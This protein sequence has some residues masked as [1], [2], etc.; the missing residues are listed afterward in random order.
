[1]LTPYIDYSFNIIHNRYNFFVA[2]DS[3]KWLDSLKVLEDIIGS[4]EFSIVQS[5]EAYYCHYFKFFN[6]T[7]SYESEFLWPSVDSDPML[8]FESFRTQL[9]RSMSPDWPYY[10]LTKRIN[11]TTIIQQIEKI[12]DSESDEFEVSFQENIVIADAFPF[13]ILETTL[14]LDFWTRFL[15]IYIVADKDTIDQAYF[16]LGKNIQ[17]ILIPDENVTLRANH[18]MV[19]STDESNYQLNSSNLPSLQQRMNANPYRLQHET[20]KN[21]WSPEEAQLFDRAREELYL[22]EKR[23]QIDFNA[24]IGKG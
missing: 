11:D 3:S 18:I 5:Y 22:D 8:V 1:M 15:D 13:W 14:E 6:E 16:D 20:T 23:L 7:H 17:K 4:N 19:L 24:I 10:K 12:F 9:L 21:H 2:V